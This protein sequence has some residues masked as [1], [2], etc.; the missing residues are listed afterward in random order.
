MHLLET[1]DRAGGVLAG[2]L[3]SSPLEE[4]DGLPRAGHARGGDAAAVAGADDDDVVGGAQ[5]LDGLGEAREGAVFAA[6][7]VDALLE[8]RGRGGVGVGVDVGVDGVG[9]EGVGFLAAG[10]VELWDWLRGSVGGG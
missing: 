5:Q 1:L 8:A 6:V 10:E 4:A 3:L 2:P 9:G 7:G